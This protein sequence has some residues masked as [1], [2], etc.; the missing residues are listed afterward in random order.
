MIHH[1]FTRHLATPGPPPRSLDLFLFQ[2]LWLVLHL[3]FR[4]APIHLPISMTLVAVSRRCL[5]ETP[6]VELNY[7]Q[8]CTAQTLNRLVVVGVI[9]HPGFQVPQIHL[10]NELLLRQVQT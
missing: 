9:Q 1:L 8:V 2:R 4:L 3:P 6:I 10:V 7:F 5:L